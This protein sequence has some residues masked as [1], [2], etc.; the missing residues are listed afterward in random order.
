[1]AEYH[2]YL[3][4]ILES[5]K[6]IKPLRI[7]LIG[8]YAEGTVD[9]DSDLDLVIILDKKRVSKNYQEKM[10]NKLLVRRCIYEFSKK[11][12]I[13][14]IVYTK[15]EFQQISELETS[16]YREINSTGKILYEKAG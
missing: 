14:L 5:L 11:I 2:R 6:S 16:F 4:E 8:S 13:D 7:I 1:M 12:P 3:P 15:E 10:D 9:E